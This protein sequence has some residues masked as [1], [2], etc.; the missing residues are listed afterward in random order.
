MTMLRDGLLDGRGVAVAGGVA[1][2]VRDAL[3]AL[4]ASVKE[5]DGSLDEE[6][7]RVW[8]E[9]AGSLYALVYDAGPAF[10]GGGQAALR[11]CIEAGWV[12]VRG[13]ATGALI[14]A[15]AGK[16][17]LIA[18]RTDSGSFA[19][20][21]RAAFENVART[22]S[23]EWARYG[24]GTVTIAPGARTS[25][26]QLAELVCY[27]VSHAGEYFTGCMLELGSSSVVRSGP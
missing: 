4:G 18:P 20:A 8:A 27:L 3:V 12:A 6:A 22:L 9:E 7:A 21:A 16:V 23:V 17:V 11:S 13:V 25:D 1:G 15:H 10:A 26:D 19:A 14:P 5:L 2:S 24:V